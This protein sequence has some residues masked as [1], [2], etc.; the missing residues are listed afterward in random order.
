LNENELNQLDIVDLQLMK[1]LNPNFKI[2]LFAS[3]RESGDFVGK[4]I[5]QK[6]AELS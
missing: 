5:V 3:F 4:D 1:Q 2:K 6:L